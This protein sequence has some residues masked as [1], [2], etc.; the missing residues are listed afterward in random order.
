MTIFS[1][2]RCWFDFS[3]N[4]GQYRYR[5]GGLVKDKKYF[6]N[7]EYDAETRKLI[8]NVFWREGPLSWEP[9]TYKYR[10]EMVFSPSFDKITR[11][12]EVQ[13]DKNEVPIRNNDESTEKFSLYD[14]FK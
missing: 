12:N 11:W 8:G 1:P 2:Q 4:S 14:L 5:D 9:R 3:C 10:I 6:E 7:I 13:Y